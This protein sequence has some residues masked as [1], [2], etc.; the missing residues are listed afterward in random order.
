MN[1]KRIYA[2]LKFKDKILLEFKDKLLENDNLNTFIRKIKNQEYVHVNG[3]LILKKIIKQTNFFF[4]R[5]SS[6]HPLLIIIL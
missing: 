4:F 2:K 1:D 3:K 6:N 5:K